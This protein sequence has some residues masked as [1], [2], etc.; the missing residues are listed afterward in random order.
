MSECC[1]NRKG[2][3]GAL[4][5]SHRQGSS[6]KTG[7]ALSLSLIHSLALIPYTR[8][9]EK[10]H[11]AVPMS[12]V[13]EKAT[14][15]SSHS[16]Q[17]SCLYRA[18]R[19]HAYTEPTGIMPIQSLQASCLYRAYRHH[20]YT[21]PTG[22]MPIQSLQASCL[23]RAY[24]HHAYTEPTGTYMS[25]LSHTNNTTPTSPV[26]STTKHSVFFISLFLFQ[27]RLSTGYGTK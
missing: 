10:L 13:R 7:L 26:H 1:S 2:F 18:Y 24:R 11:Q 23:Y 4:T 6:L 9:V 27:Q 22:I 5:L 14:R 8:Q 15:V 21:E 16:L 3:S 20:A 19:H 25:N 12:L 17:A